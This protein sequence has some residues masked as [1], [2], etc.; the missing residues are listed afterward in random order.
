MAIIAVKFVFKLKRFSHKLRRFS[1]PSSGGA[2]SFDPEEVLG[3]SEFDPQEV[4][5]RSKFDPEEVLGRS[6][7]P[8]VG[9]MSLRAT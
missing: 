9:R 2:V 3:S 7:G 1:S 4:L 8:T 6:G 5:G